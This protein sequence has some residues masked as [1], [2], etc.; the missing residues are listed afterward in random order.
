MSE[1]KLVVEQTENGKFINSEVM[2]TPEVQKLAADAR[3][4]FF[5][6]EF[7]LLYNDDWKTIRIEDV[8]DVNFGRMVAQ[9]LFIT[10]NKCTTAKMLCANQIGLPYNVAVVNVREPLFFINPIILDENKLIEYIESDNSYPQKIA[11]TKHFGRVLISAMNFKSPIWFGSKYN[12]LSLLDNQYAT[13]HPIIE[14]CIA[15]QH[16]ID[17][18][19]GISMFERNTDFTYKRKSEPNRNQIVTIVKDETE[20]KFK[21]KLIQ[22]YL[23]TGWILK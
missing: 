22:P 6:K 20:L 23:K 21:Y 9:K 14:E 1:T 19:N 11:Q 5:E 17:V 16:A 3:K 8:I 13:T 12:Q 4:E 7:P 2:N 15:I 10:L 18:L